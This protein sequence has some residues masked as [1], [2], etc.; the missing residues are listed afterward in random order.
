MITHQGIIWIKK[1]LLRLISGIFVQEMMVPE[2]LWIAVSGVKCPYKN[3]LIL[4]SDRILFSRVFILDPW[5]LSSQTITLICK[6]LLVILRLGTMHSISL[7]NHKVS[8]PL[9]DHRR[10]IPLQFLSLTMI[11]KLFCKEV[12]MTRGSGCQLFRVL[13]NLLFYRTMDHTIRFLMF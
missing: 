5:L 7:D 8:G 11:K 2:G 6:M 3:S 12:C 9:R 4:P 1:R 10:V 13:C